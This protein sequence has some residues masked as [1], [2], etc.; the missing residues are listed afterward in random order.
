MLTAE[1]NLNHVLEELNQRR[2]RVACLMTLADEE[3]KKCEAM[4]LLLDEATRPPSK[5]LAVT[6][7]YWPR[8][9]EYRGAF[10]E[11]FSEIDI[12]LAILHRLLTDFTSQAPAIATA[13]R[14]RERRFLAQCREDLF[15]G[16]SHQWV[17][18]HSREVCPG[19]YADTNTSHPTKLQKIRKAL[20]AVGL[21]LGA[22]VKIVWQPRFSH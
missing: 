11:C 16:K 14:G 18:K 22:D 17:E 12:Y 10:H 6:A 8:G 4:E 20:S 9:F 3:R 13:L 5:P 21:K 2:D 15:R 7:R 1:T 19:W